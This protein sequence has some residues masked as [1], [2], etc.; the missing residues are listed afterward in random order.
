MS[1]EPVTVVSN[2]RREVLSDQLISGSPA[3]FSSV[4]I[5]SGVYDYLEVTLD[6]KSATTGAQGDAIRVV[7][8]SDNTDANY[9]WQ[10]TTDGQA[11]ATSTNSGGDTR[12]A[13][14]VGTAHASNHA[15]VFSP[16]RMLIQGISNGTV[17]TTNMNHNLQNRVAT[18]LD[19]YIERW[20]S[21][22]EN[23][24]N[25]TNLAITTVSGASFAIGSKLRVVGVKVVNNLESI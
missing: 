17:Y 11:G 21:T 4:T 14:R 19:N 8:N 15:S 22:W 24:A 20:F 2:E 23:T 9:N 12:H 10:R 3:A 5:A 13:G 6:G 16:N 7:Y 1:Y 18:S 25:V